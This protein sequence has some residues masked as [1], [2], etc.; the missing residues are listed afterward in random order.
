MC[1]GYVVAFYGG[2]GVWY[3][4]LGVEGREDEGFSGEKGCLTV[5][6]DLRLLCLWFYRFAH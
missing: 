6:G 3:L 4:V 5:I 1:C 2:G